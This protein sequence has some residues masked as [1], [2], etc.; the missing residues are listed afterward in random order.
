MTVPAA[1]KSFARSQDGTIV[2]FAAVALSVMVGMAAL[3]FDFGR[4][5]TT[6][7][8][9]Q[10][11]ADSVALA[12]AGELDGQI[13][14]ITRATNAAANMIS[15]TQTFGVR[16]RDQALSGAADYQIF[17]YSEPANAATEPAQSSELLDPA[18]AA[19]GIAA[20]FVRVVVRDHEVD[21]PL[22]AATAAL[23]GH[24][25]R[26]G[27]VSAEA[28]A[29]FTLVACDITPMFFCLPQPSLSVSNGQMIKMVSQGGGSDQWGPGN[30]GFLEANAVLGIDADGAC[31]SAP[32]GQEDAC[33]LAASQAVSMCFDQRGVETSPGLSVGNMIAGFN[34]RFDQ[35][36]S[37]AGQFQN[38]KK[39]DV[40]NFAAAPNVLDGWITQMQGNNCTSA[41]S[42]DYENDGVIDPTA[43]VG[44]PLDD[45]FDDGDCPA[46]RI[47]DGDFSTGLQTYLTVNYGADF[48]TVPATG[49]PAWFPQSGTRLD[50]YN[51]ET[52]NQAALESI[53]SAGGKAESSLPACQPPSNGAANPQRRTIVAAGI[54]CATYA[55]QLNGGSGTI[56][57]TS[58]VEIFLVRPSKA[59]ATGADAVIWGEV[60]GTIESGSGGSGVGGILHDVV[61]LYR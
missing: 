56:P 42:P 41:Q 6:Q 58:F 25:Y 51:A 27:T 16:N 10:S 43:T 26:F 29:G 61:Q 14:S 36:A 22:A 12:A 31:A 2:V 13:D 59:G 8:E 21:A 60:V 50:I 38:D 5:T 3:A 23:V 17:F 45:C 18:D 39:Y 7:S 52:A 40:D 1:I 37:A 15:D 34:T 32:P 48:S 4:V 35:Y 30:F 46:T 47:G 11:F 44:L 9:L 19:S 53:L 28:V 54:D 20:A 33:A 57:V 24:P 55:S 49:I